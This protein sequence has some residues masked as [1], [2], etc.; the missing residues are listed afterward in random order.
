MAEVSFIDSTGIALLLRAHRRAE[1]AGGQLRV[2]EP[3]GQVVR[4]LEATGAHEILQ[5]VPAG[6]A[7]A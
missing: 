3:V 7:E 2:I 4:V 5:I 1:D 6:R